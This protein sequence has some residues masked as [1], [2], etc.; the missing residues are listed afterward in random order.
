MLV[1]GMK[2][3]PETFLLRLLQGLAQQ[4]IEITIAGPVQ[5]HKTILTRSGFRWLT[6]PAWSG[7]IPLRLLRLVAAVGAGAARSA[8][9]T[10]WLARNV[11]RCPDL[12]G[13]LIQSTRLL[14]F[15]GRRWDLIYFPW[16]YAAAGVLP[17]F[18]LGMP[19]VVSCRGAQVSVV[20]HN[21]S[22]R[23]IL[24]GLEETFRQAAFVHCVSR[25]ILEEAQAYG[26]DPNKAHI[27][28]PAVN[29][30]FF[31]PCDEVGGASGDLLRIITTG[32][33]IWR[34]GHE[35]AVTALARLRDRG[36]AA[37]L[38]IIGEGP[39]RARVLYTAHDLGLVD[40]VE[41]LG[42]LA[43]E[44]VRDRLRAAD[45]FL[46]SSLSEG[47][48]NAALE[49]MACG[50]PVVTTDCGGMRE[51]IDDGVEGFVV[52][53]REPQPMAEALMRLALDPGL[54]L[55]MGRAARQRVEREFDLRQQVDRWAELCRRTVAEWRARV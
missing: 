14:P 47:I 27:I 28:R 6:V 8:S 24:A 9:D 41:L 17:A 39:D 25:A 23:A 38:E 49:A 36:I 50:L 42:R 7:P 44:Q 20:P 43:P 12:R 30:A 18:E 16:I 51:A 15:A 52:P 19:I 1:V 55:R 32:S 54:R 34:K 10:R 31:H 40:S 45:V 13:K 5:P 4:G 2:W 22:R 3:P 33:L 53:V 26:L 37:R 48:S 11:L 35:F 21:P 29:P 46:L